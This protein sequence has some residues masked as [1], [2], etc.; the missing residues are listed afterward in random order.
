VVAVE[1]HVLQGNGLRGRAGGAAQVS[2]G[3][4]HFVGADDVEWVE[5]VKEH[6]RGPQRG[7]GGHCLVSGIRVS[8]EVGS[9]EGAGDG[10]G[11][12]G[13]Q[14]TDLERPVQ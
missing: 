9:P 10:C 11:G 8:G 12:D 4:Q 1:N 3:V 14:L 7:R 13:E 5:A 6:H 2:P